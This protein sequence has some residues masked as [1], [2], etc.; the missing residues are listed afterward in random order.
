MT[1]KAWIAGVPLV[2]VPLMSLVAS[3][4]P[5]R[6]A[7]PQEIAQAE[8]TRQ[9]AAAER[10]LE[11]ADLALTEAY[12]CCGRTTTPTLIAAYE[13]WA[14]AKEAVVGPDWRAKMLKRIQAEYPL[15]SP[16]EARALYE[17]HTGERFDP[18]SPP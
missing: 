8:A 15:A 7:S 17:R 6:T 4:A 14:R 3:M 10:E 12:R 18:N 11:A 9:R 2:C 5:E 13:R 16:A 1:L